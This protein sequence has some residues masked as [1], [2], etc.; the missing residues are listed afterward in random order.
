MLITI[1]IQSALISVQA[2]IG[3]LNF[4]RNGSRYLRCSY[5]SLWSALLE[6]L[7]GEMPQQSES[8]KQNTRVSMSNNQKITISFKHKKVLYQLYHNLILY[9]LGILK[10]KKALYLSQIHSTYTQDNITQ[11]LLYLDLLKFTQIMFNIQHS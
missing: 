6:T 9:F 5:A 3:T 4:F 8:G 2:N 11:K 1:S 7:F 10:D